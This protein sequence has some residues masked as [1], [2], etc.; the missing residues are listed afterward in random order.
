MTVENNTKSGY[1]S[2]ALGCHP[3]RSEGSVAMGNK[4]LR[5]AQHDSD[6]FSMTVV[7]HFAVALWQGVNVPRLSP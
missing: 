3:E 6:V 7:L 5:C 1:V 4:M 2:T